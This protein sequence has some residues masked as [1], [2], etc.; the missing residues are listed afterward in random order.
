MGYV[1]ARLLPLARTLPRRQA[2]ALQL[3]LVLVVI[4]LLNTLALI[5]AYA[6]MTSMAR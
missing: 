2:E 6:F 3:A 5:G 4:L 1:T